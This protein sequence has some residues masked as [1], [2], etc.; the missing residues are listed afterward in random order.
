MNRERVLMEAR[1]TAVA[2]CES[3]Y[4]APKERTIPAGGDAALANMKLGVHMMRSGGYI[5]DHDVNVATRAA[6]ILC[7][8]AISP[9]SPVSEEQ[10]LNL[11]REEFLSLCGEQKTQERIRYTLK[12]G[13]PLRN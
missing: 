11:E 7:G 4:S 12:T 10:L 9:G 6:S 13:K 5:S 1:A 2:L 8:N 3:G